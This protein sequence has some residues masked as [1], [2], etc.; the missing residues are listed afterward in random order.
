VGCAER[1]CERSAGP[2]PVG[3]PARR[4]RALE[5]VGKVLT[6]SDEACKRGGHACLNS[7]PG[8][9]DSHWLTRPLSRKYDPDKAPPFRNLDRSL[10]G[11]YGY[12]NTTPERFQEFCQALLMA[13][14][15]GLQCFPVGQ[16]DGGR[17]AW[18]PDTRTV[19][20]VKFRRNDEPES[21]A[22]MIETLEHELP[23]IKR[24][25]SLGARNSSPR[26][27]TDRSRPAVANQ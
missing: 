19:L 2:R 4:S 3:R 13:E 14:Y 6:G 26:R 18:H 22:W 8:E 12:E 17:D 25:I 20:Q 7:L 9:I 21:A 11:T 1:A 23:K 27:G 16:P 24:L 5:S 10:V 15:Q